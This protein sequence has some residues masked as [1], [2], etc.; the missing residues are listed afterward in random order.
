[1]DE[2]N[3]RMKYFTIEDGSPTGKVVV[4][5]MKHDK[6]GRPSSGKSHE[7]ETFDFEKFTTI[8]AMVQMGLDNGF[9]REQIVASVERKYTYDDSL[10]EIHGNVK[11]RVMGEGDEFNDKRKDFEA[12][13]S[14]LEPLTPAEEA[15][16]TNLRSLGE[17]GLKRAMMFNRLADSAITYLSCVKQHPDAQVII[18]VHE[19]LT[20]MEFKFF[21]KSKDTSFLAG[22]KLA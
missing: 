7:F 22:E 19:V 8:K 17:E 13:K 1:M 16:I 10:R 5:K 15:F 4:G 9:T 3:N 11:R 2:V 18:G 14:E 12:L 6:R 21:E 20:A